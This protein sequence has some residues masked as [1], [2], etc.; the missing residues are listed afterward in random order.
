MTSLQHCLERVFAAN[1]PQSV[2]RTLLAVMPVIVSIGTVHAREPESPQARS[3]RALIHRADELIS[4]KN[5]P[6][7]LDE[8]FA[9]MQALANQKDIG[10]LRGSLLTR[11]AEIALI[12]GR[13]AD[14]KRTYTNVMDDTIATVEA[15]S[16]AAYQLTLLCQGGDTTLGLRAWDEYERHFPALQSAGW[17]ID[18]PASGPRM[19]MAR[20]PYERARLLLS[21]AQ[22]IPIRSIEQDTLLRRSLEHIEL[23]LASPAGKGKSPVSPGLLPTPREVLDAKIT[24]EARLGDRSAAL[25]SLQTLAETPIGRAPMLRYETAP[26]A[27]IA[28]GLYGRRISGGLEDAKYWQ[29]FADFAKEA[30]RLVPQSESTRHALSLALAQAQIKHLGQVREGMST[31]ESLAGSPSGDTG[32][33]E[34]LPDQH[35]LALRLLAE[36]NKSLGKSAEALGYYDRYLSEHPKRYDRITIARERS[37]LLEDVAAKRIP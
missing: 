12:R 28:T 18:S 1:L 2:V 37:Q 10:S 16:M 19:L 20:A 5:S 35:A 31:L 32:A 11:C 3:A 29:A 33:H 30:N 13:L 27:L 9:S 21:A 25:L 36:S 7:E 6:G 8:M 26:V 17:V 22:R 23:Y 4:S 24:A 34:L 15:R 14:A